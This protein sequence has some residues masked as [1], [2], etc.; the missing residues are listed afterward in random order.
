MKK[1][2]IAISAAFLLLA[3]CAS[4]M[5]KDIRVETEADPKANLAGYS[6][7]TWLGSAAI[8]YDPEG[9]WE[10]PEFDMDNEIRF[11]IDRELAARRPAPAAAP[12]GAAQ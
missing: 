7:Y 10:P 4:T 6:C 8:I 12:A 5:T 3:G 9:Q 1:H 2:L 11:L